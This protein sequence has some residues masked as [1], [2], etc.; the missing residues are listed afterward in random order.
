MKIVKISLVIIVVVAISFFV[1]QSLISTPTVG[2]TR[3]PANS[4]VAK[5]QNEIGAIESKPDNAFCKD[6]YNEVMYHIDDFY[7]NSKLGKT[8]LENDQWK[9]NLSKQ[10]YATYAGKFIR[11]AYFVFNHSD[12]DG[13]NL[14]FIRGEYPVLQNS[15]LLEKNGAIDK[16][17]N[18][19][20]GIFSKYDEISA[21][22]SSCSGFSYSTEKLS[23]TYPLAEISQNISRASSYLDNKLGNAYLNNCTR[24]HSELKEIPKILFYAHVRYLDNMIKSW[25]NMF[26][27]YSSQKAYADG[28]YRVIEN[29]ID[30]LDNDI[31]NVSDFDSEYSRLKEKWQA[32]GTKAY[33][34]FGT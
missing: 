22:I 31:Y 18:E 9:E 24:L 29:K 30:E 6:Y 19:I 26:S 8:K 16:K 7:K 34:Y 20:K 4:F 11:Q 15:P 5:I 33:N 3:P 32:D 10:L 13:N 1:I 21:F 12:W 28:L 27:N 25:S 23:D 14:N 2:Q 17:F